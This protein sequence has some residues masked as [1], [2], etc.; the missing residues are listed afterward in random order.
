LKDFLQPEKETNGLQPI[1]VTVDGEVR[2][3]YRQTGDPNTGS[4]DAIYFGGPDGIKISETDS[5][6][7]EGFWKPNLLGGSVEFDVDLS[8]MECGCV[9]AFYLIRMPAKD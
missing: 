8:N 9:A 4:A 3:F 5:V 2:T 1:E 6:T 7:P